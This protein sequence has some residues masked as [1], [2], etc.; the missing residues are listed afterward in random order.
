M[1]SR[2]GARHVEAA[3]RSV[4]SG[5]SAAVG[6]LLFAA[7]LLPAAAATGAPARP[8]M[9]LVGRVILTTEGGDFINP[10]SLGIDPGLRLLVTM[11]AADSRLHLV[12]LDTLRA[13]GSIELDGYEE[14]STANGGSGGYA[15]DPVH[16]TAYLSDYAPDTGIPR[17]WAVSL[18]P[19]FVNRSLE[20]PA[21][22]VLE[23][24]TALEYDPV[25]DRLYMTTSVDENSASIPA[26]TFGGAVRNGHPMA[27]HQVDGAKLRAG[28]AD[29]IEWSYRIPGCTGQSQLSAQSSRP[30][31]VA[32]SG[33]FLSFPCEG[34]TDTTSRTGL[35][36]N[37]SGIALLHLGGGDPD[38]F[39]LEFHPFG[40]NLDNGRVAGDSVRGIVYIVDT[41]QRKLWAFDTLHRAW[42]GSVPYPSANGGSQGFDE[43]SGRA[44]L[45]NSAGMFVTEGAALPLPQG[46]RLA[47][48]G[49]EGSRPQADGR[50]YFDPVRRHL[51]VRGPLQYSK[52]GIIETVVKASLLVF[53]DD[54]PAVLPFSEP[55]PDPATRDIPEAPGRTV[56][57]F[58][59]HG[60]AFAAR[61]QFAGGI[62]SL[63]AQSL[64]GTLNTEQAQFQFPLN[65]GSRGV[66]LGRVVEADLDSSGAVALAASTTLDGGTTSDLAQVENPQ[67][68]DPAP[69]PAKDAFQEALAALRETAP[70]QSARGLIDERLT[71]AACQD[72][73]GEPS[74]P[75]A[76]GSEVSCDLG[77]SSVRA[78][79]VSD[80]SMASSPIQIGYASSTV[81][82]VR[83]EMLG[84]VAKVTAEARG[85]NILDLIHIGRVEQIVD[86]AAHGRPGTATSKVTTLMKQVRLNDVAGNELFA[87]GFGEESCDP[88]VVA[89]AINR[90]FTPRIHAEA[91]P[92]NTNP[93]VAGSPGGAQAAVIKDPYR[94]WNDVNVH[95]DGQHEV[96]ALQITIFHDTT[97]PSREILQ[98]AA[99]EADAHYAIAPAPFGLPP[100]GGS[101]IGD[102]I[103]TL[104]PIGTLGPNGPQFRPPPNVQ[105]GPSVPP[106]ERI[107]RGLAFL[108]QSPGDGLLLALAWAFLLGPIYLL[109]RRTRLVRAARRLGGM[110]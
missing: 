44:Y 72:F 106:I 40:V 108:L 80:P 32:R 79:A 67:P 10:P 65:E 1:Q 34:T 90:F 35:Q 85:V 63:I 62:R 16:H 13:V 93:L 89:Q 52:E 8:G 102:V 103:D 6:M 24:I 100:G 60:A 101:T 97:R 38:E 54:I 12:S 43:K 82:L 23:G 33:G 25:R 18:T 95:E 109:V 37:E 4:S 110:T 7:L 28:R 27:V 50:F 26:G 81:E 55:D 57:T 68:P 46:S 20:L 15:L 48:P 39:V 107:A 76:F 64:G 92:R 49:P 66:F 86:T 47:W 96:A 29:A 30:G 59:S 71:P 41:Q 5:V 74:N 42:I 78:S 19:S 87:C 3:E 22:F 77:K 75:S 45:A 17:I 56:S 58:S 99:V 11:P 2:V 14:T 36:G 51:F 88:L 69:Q 9:R 73:G 94:F 83:D 61:Y 70:Y 84:A 91:P 31:F 104:A 21:E 98:F 53:R 105:P